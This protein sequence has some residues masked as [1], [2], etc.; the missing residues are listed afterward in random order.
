MHDLALKRA[1]EILWAGGVIAYPTEA[2]W[3]LGCDPE[4]KQACLS[5][6]QIKQRQA[7]KGMI[8]IA[9]KL[10]QFAALL[11]PLS[12]EQRAVLTKAWQ[13]QEK[14]GA[15]TMLVP[16][17]LDQVPWWVKGQHPA[18]AL[19]VSRHPLVQSLCEAFG[20]A[21]VSTSANVSGKQAALSRLTVQRQLGA[22][23]DFIVPGE[24]GGEKNPSRIIDLETGKTLRAS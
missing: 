7:E 13:Q 8:L 6:L 21:L 17:L 19:R 12:A 11:A 14:T 23:L 1:A 16:D 24:L 3:G 15:V 10:D 4:N 5:L 2:V 20:G 22:Q 18:V 9:G